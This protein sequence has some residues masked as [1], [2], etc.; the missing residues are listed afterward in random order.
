MENNLNSKSN[1]PITEINA[2]LNKVL[3]QS[4]QSINEEV[5]AKIHKKRGPK[6]PRNKK[7][8]PLINNSVNNPALIKYS[9]DQYKNTLAGVFIISGMYLEK[10]TGFKGFAMQPEEIEA[11]ASQ[12][13]EVCDQFMP[14]IESKYIAV[15]GFVLG[16]A[17]VYGMKYM[18][19]KEWQAEQSK[20]VIKKEEIKKDE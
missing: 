11:L 16:C 8:E 19:F 6:G 7:D 4:A 10:S 5:S 18:A 9:K 3:N 17:S 2:D 13:A 12:G 14:A 20:K 1:Q 15:G